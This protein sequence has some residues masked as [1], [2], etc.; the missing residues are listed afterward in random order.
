MNSIRRIQITLL[1]DSNQTTEKLFNLS[2][3]SI[4]TYNYEQ[5]FINMPLVWMG[6]SSTPTIPYYKT[7][8]GY[9]N[10]T[11]NLRKFTYTDSSSK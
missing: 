4:P 2:I 5:P 6:K 10:G 9:F 1:T 3:S 7:N 11:M 8:L